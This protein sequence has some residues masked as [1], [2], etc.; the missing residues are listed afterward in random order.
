MSWKE[1]RFSLQEGITLIDGWNE[2]DQ[3]SEGSGK[4]AVL[5]AICWGIYGKLPKDTNINDVIK[6][7]EK[8]TDVELWFGEEYVVK[9]TRNPNDLMILRSVKDGFKTIKGKDARETQKLIEDFVGLSFEAFCNSVYFAQNNNKK[10]I[11]ET[12][13]NRGRI[14]SEIQDLQ[15][16]DKARKEVLD[17]LKAESASYTT[18]IHDIE[19]T[20]RDLQLNAQ[21]LATAEEQIKGMQTQWQSQINSLKEQIIT[22]HNKLAALNADIETREQSAASVSQLDP[23]KKLELQNQITEL[24]LQIAQLQHKKTNL[25]SLKR[26]QEMKKSEGQ[27]YGA[28][29]KK[30]EARQAELTQF[31]ADPSTVPNFN[32]SFSRVTKELADLQLHLQNPDKPCPTCSTIITASPE[33]IAKIKTDINQAQTQLEGYKDAAQKELTSTEAEKQT[34]LAH[35]QD[36]SKSLQEEIPSADSITNE[37]SELTRT[38]AQ[39]SAAIVEIEDQERNA[40]SLQAVL[41]SLKQQRD[42]INAEVQSLAQRCQEIQSNPPVQDTENIKALVLEKQTLLDKHQTLVRLKEEK[43]IYVKQ[44]ESLKAGFKEIKSHIFTSAL[45]EINARVQKYLEKLFEVPV[46]LRFTNENMKI[47]TETSINGHV[48]GLGLMSGGQFRRLSLATDLALADV[49]NSRKQGKVNTIILDEYFKDLSEQSME[50]CLHLLESR[51]QPVLL[52]EHNSIFKNIINNSFFVKYE[53]GTS[54]ATV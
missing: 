1:L 31:L 32:M 23:A 54:Y 39:V 36:L 35:L 16:F 6:H 37:I 5:N 48:Q 13:E 43:A 21:K 44:L 46:K 34:I 52:I 9:R 17:L 14:L 53:N 22:S 29:Y 50:K 18:M 4:S 10:W 28:K 30:L 11:T 15:I 41:G 24:N 12:Q 42:Q 33:V 20:D 3:T 8:G 27:Q 49:V 19:L 38:K 25:D 51:K 45:N 2:D 26:A 7:G 47:G 40:A